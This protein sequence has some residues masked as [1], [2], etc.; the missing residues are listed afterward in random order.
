[1]TKGCSDAYLAEIDACPEPGLD[2]LFAAALGRYLD[3]IGAGVFIELVE[4]EVAV[5]VAGGFRNGAAVLVETN[6]RAFN[7]IHHAVALGRERAADEAFR[8]APE[9]AVVDA[10][11]G[12]Q[13]AL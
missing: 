9:I 10:R 1:M 3:R 11:A 6:A 13:F 5:I 8:V 2:T 4:L 12:A 7:A